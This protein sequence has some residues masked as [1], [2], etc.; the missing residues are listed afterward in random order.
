MPLTVNEICVTVKVFPSASVS[1]VNTFPVA[2]VSSFTVLVSLTVVGP[3]L[4][5]ATVI[6]ISPVSVP[7]F[8][9]LTV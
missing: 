3:S 6:F 1:L 9:S 5:G 4:T 8:P 7:P 2:V